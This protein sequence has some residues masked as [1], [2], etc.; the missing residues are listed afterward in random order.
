[1]SYAFN[2]GLTYS[3]E[4]WPNNI[5]GNDFKNVRVLA[6]LDRDSAN[7]LIS[8]QSMHVNVYP[9]LPAGTPNNPGQYN[10]IKIQTASGAVTCLGLPWIK[11]SSIRVV[12]YK[13]ML[14]TLDGIT[15]EDV[16]RA[17]NALIKNGFP[18]PTITLE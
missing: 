13:K 16:V 12:E 7:Q 1:M 9:Y 5:L 10:Y 2:I 18:N 15:M 6:I 11:E 17:Q 8:T 3:F 14:I 4:V